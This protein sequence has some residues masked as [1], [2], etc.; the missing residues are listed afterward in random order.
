MALS[1]RGSRRVRTKRCCAGNP[2]AWRAARS[3][4]P[5]A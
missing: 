2:R 5:R 1:R 3:T 4:A